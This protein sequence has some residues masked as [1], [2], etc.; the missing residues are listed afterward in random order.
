LKL[1]A[2]QPPDTH[3]L[4]AAI[5]WFELGNLNEASNEL[6]NISPR[7]KIHPDVLNVRYRIYD[8]AKKWDVCLDLSEAL[9]TIIPDE[10]HGWVSK[11]IS[12][13]RLGRTQDA[14]DTLQGQL[15]RF[16]REWTF[17]YNLACYA[18]QLGRLREAEQCLQ[19]AIVL[20]D[21]KEVRRIIMEDPDLE[22]LRGEFRL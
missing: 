16:A 17:H 14:W 8:A 13:Y 11:S 21:P 15:H 10:P 5:G 6:E 1:Q 2:I 19:R 18:C 3:H 22:P 7:M 12:L 20:G 4:N 9:T